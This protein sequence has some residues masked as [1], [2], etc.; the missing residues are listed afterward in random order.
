MPSITPGLNSNQNLK[1]YAITQALLLG[2]TSRHLLKWL[3][4]MQVTLKE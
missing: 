4:F 1:E 2:V 3:D